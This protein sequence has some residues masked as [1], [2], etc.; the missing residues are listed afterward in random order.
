MQPG[1]HDH[2]RSATARPLIEVLLNSQTVDDR[3]RD[4]V[5]RYRAT[6]GV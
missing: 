6:I 1:G 4:I 2:S 5:R 3:L